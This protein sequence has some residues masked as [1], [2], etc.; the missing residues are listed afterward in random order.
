[1]GWRRRAPSDAPP[2]TNC[3]EKRTG[4][5]TGPGASLCHLPAPSGDSPQGAVRS[6]WFQGPS[7]TRRHRAEGPLSPVWSQCSD[8]RNRCPR[9]SAFCP[10]C[11]FD[12]SKYL[13]DSLSSGT[14]H[15]VCPLRR[16]HRICL[17]NINIH[18]APVRRKSYSKMSWRGS[19]GVHGGGLGCP[20]RRSGVSTENN[21][22][23]HHQLWDKGVTWP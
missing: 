9:R 20:R 8:S 15:R 3:K 19:R 22:M 23:T 5:G 6:L 1:M 14:C 11:A 4:C 2:L 7:C 13:W 18:Q 10:R 16:K 12:E 21:A 17:S